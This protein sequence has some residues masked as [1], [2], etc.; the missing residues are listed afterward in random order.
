MSGS[1]N[2]KALG[3]AAEI[4]VTK[5]EEKISSCQTVTQSGLRPFTVRLSYRLVV[6]L[7]M[8]LSRF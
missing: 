7:L 1:R 2:G 3:N 6:S 4:A 5:P 8:V